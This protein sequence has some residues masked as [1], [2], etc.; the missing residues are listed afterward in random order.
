MGGG[1]RRAE[2]GR[3]EGL[4]PG[5]S[6]AR[7]PNSS[8]LRGIR[9]PPAARRAGGRGGRISTFPC[10]LVRSGE[11]RCS[12]VREG[13][14]RGRHRGPRGRG[15]RA[16][17]AR[18]RPTCGRG[19]RPPGQGQQFKP[20][21]SPQVMGCREGG[22]A[23]R[24]EA[25][26]ALRKRVKPGCSSQCGRTSPWRISAGLRPARPSLR[27][28]GERRC[29]RKNRKSSKYS[30]PA[31]RRRKNTSSRIHRASSRR[32]SASWIAAVSSCRAMA[33]RSR[34]GRRRHGTGRWARPPLDRRAA[35]CRRR[36]RC[37]RGRGPA[38]RARG[39]ELPR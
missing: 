29:S 18:G 33:S 26:V 7:R 2:A 24:A 4:T 21:A 31:W 17:V 10:G 35:L 5:A 9:S 39:D 23:P 36:P 37:T 38:R 25:Q 30:G 15:T 11:P 32:S 20:I 14:A 22:V 16:P 6:D 19:S 1:V 28:R 13:A 12:P 27:L 3:G 34:R 8:D